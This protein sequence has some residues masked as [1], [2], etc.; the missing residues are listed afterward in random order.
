MI[1]KPTRLLV[2]IRD[3][4]LCQVCGRNLAHAYL[5]GDYSLQHR[6]ARGM[7][8]SKRPDT[9]SPANLILVCGHA[10]DPDGCH[11]RI[12]SNPAWAAERGLRL[13]QNQ[14]PAEC[15]VLTVDGWRLLNDDGTRYDATAPLEAL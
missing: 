10:T 14:T 11:Y 13:R 3:E 4:W 8:G 5:S 2:L 9:N 12:E 15:P 7:G 6:R 1:P